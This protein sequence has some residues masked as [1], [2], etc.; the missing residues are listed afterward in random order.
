VVVYNPEQAQRD[1][2]R[3]EKILARLEQELEAL[4]DLTGKRHKKAVCA[5]V[6]HRTLG[7]Y[8]KELKSGALRIDRAKVRAEERLDGKYLLSSSDESL[9]AEEIAW[10][11]KQ[12]QEVERAFRSL[13]QT[14]ELRP[15][16]HRKE[17]RIRTHVTLCWLALLLVRVLERESGESWERARRV[18]DRIHL[19][20]VETPEGRML[21]RTELTEEQ[22][23]LLKGLGMKPPPRVERV[24]LTPAGL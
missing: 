5:L 7:R 11:Y 12:L 14:L 19:L 22:R 8:L 10:G 16:Y 17:E 15:M 4:G 20:E 1:R 3:R 21:Q 24:E 9:S 6:A 18:L 23:E 13:K 2:A